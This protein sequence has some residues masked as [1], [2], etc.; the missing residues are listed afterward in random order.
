MQF[1]ATT[2]RFPFD[3]SSRSDSQTDNHTDSLQ[4]NIIRE[5]LSHHKTFLKRAPASAVKKKR[6]HKSTGQKG[7]ATTRVLL[8][9]STRAKIRTNLSSI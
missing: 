9:L 2:H 1:M 5:L 8:V 6:L 3:H 7:R 4:S